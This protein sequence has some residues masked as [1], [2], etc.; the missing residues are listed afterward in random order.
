MKAHVTAIFKVL[1]V[2]NRTQAALAARSVG[3]VFASWPGVATRRGGGKNH[4]FCRRQLM[5]KKSPA[6]FSGE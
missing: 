1:G 3:V 6:I 5:S 2:A 4:A